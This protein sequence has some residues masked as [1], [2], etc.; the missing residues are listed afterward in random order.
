MKSVRKKV[1]K[2]VFSIFSVTKMFFFKLWTIPWQI[3]A[4]AGLFSGKS[5]SLY[6]SPSVFPNLTIAKMF[7]HRLCITTKVQLIHIG[8]L[9]NR[10]T[11]IFELP[12]W[13]LN[14]SMPGMVFRPFVRTFQVFF[15]VKTTEFWKVRI[16]F[17]KTLK[18]CM[19]NIAE[20]PV[21]E[22]VWTIQKS[23]STKL[24]YHSTLTHKTCVKWLA[25][26]PNIFRK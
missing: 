4:V 21:D 19:K 16:F 15:R 26:S 20:P 14:T 11:F 2:E 17:P 3:F 7:Y 23:G 22:M 9:M 12:F 18:L 1:K 13:T 24:K 25:S 6:I 10:G 8:N 5:F